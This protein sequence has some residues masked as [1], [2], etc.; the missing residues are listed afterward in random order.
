MLNHAKALQGYKLEGRDGEIGK[1]DE[2]YFDDQYWVVRY[3]VADTGN[4]FTGRQVLISPYAL[5]E[6]N[7]SKHNIT[8]GLTKKQIEESPSLDTDLPVSRQFESDYYDHYGWPRYWTGS[9]M[10]G[11]FSTPNSNVENWK[12]IT[13][14]NKAWDPHLRSTNKV[15]GYG[16]HAEDGEI[17]HIKDFII[18]DTTWAIRYLIVDTQNWWP[19]KQVLISP[20]WVE[21]VSWE[22]KKVVVNLMR[23]TIKL[24]PE[25][26][27]DALP[28]RIYEIG[29]HQHYHRPGYWD[30][31]EPDVHEH[32]SWRTHG[33][34]TVAL[35]NF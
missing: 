24:A 20:E 16:I 15:S 6:V 25:Y 12:K 21:Q 9:N 32:S 31:P 14:L 13:Q 4:W 30:K 18:D 22:E 8:I 10:W 19:G 34:P 27:E 3:L 29:L 7:F 26:I 28:T 23:E 17:G 2:F 11:M 5:G 35:T 1:V 33:E